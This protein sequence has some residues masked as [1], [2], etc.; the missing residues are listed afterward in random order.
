MRVLVTGAT[1]T[2]GKKVMKTLEQRGHEP[3]GL[4]RRPGANLRVGDVATGEGLTQAVVGVDAI[5]HAASNPRGRAKARATDIEGTRRLAKFGIPLTFVSI[6]GVDQSPFHY[7]RTKYEAEQ[8]LA[9][10]EAAW[11]I[12]RSTQF[13]EFLD[14]LLNS[15][16]SLGS[17][18]PW[19]SPADATVL[20]PSDWS[21][22]S[23]SA[24]DVAEYLA[25]VVERGP[26]FVID[27]VG[28]PQRMTTRELADQ[29]VGVRGGRVRALP[30]F[31]R[32]AASFK[33]GV[34][35]P[36]NPDHVGAMTWSEYLS[37]PAGD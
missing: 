8:F 4:S 36:Q 14:Y 20:V 29:W 23:V 15:S 16:R 2:L 30:T 32:L 11:S 34:T 12:V 33:A 19:R 37:G 21:V 26:T 18:V 22:G 10:S 28:G 6:V 3:I 9:E 31:G 17:R 24:W 27:Q 13:H 7:Y 1:G 35:V 25:D 5:V